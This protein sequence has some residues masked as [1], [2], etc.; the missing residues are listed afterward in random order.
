MKKNKPDEKNQPKITGFTTKNKKNSE[1]VTPITPT[2]ASPKP[3]PGVK[4]N[5][6]PILDIKSILVIT[7]QKEL[8]IRLFSDATQTKMHLKMEFASDIDPTCFV[9]P[10]FYLEL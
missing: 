7:P 4:I 10:C 5:G 9:S 1:N 6:E 8:D 2:F 3:R